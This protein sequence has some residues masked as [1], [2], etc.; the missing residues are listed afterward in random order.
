VRKQLARAFLRPVGELN[1]R[2]LAYGEL[3]RN[4][5]AMARFGEGLRA[6][7]AIAKRLS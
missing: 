7:D 3:E 6:I 1:V 2:Y 4:R 5:A